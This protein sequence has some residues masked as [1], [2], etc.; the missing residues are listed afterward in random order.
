MDGVFRS[1]RYWYQNATGP[2][3]KL[4]QNITTDLTAYLIRFLPVIHLKEDN[5]SIYLRGI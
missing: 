1:S 2:H 3:R 4:F 5:G